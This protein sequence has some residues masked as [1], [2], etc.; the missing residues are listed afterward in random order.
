MGARVETVKGNTEDLESVKA[1]F[2]SRL[3][4]AAPW[5]LSVGAGLDFFYMVAHL[6]SDSSHGN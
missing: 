3:L 1:P 5:S 2:T 6:P 4:R